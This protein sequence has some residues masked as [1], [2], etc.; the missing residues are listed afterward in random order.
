MQY[1]RSYL[2]NFTRRILTDIS[3]RYDHVQII[4]IIITKINELHFVN[5]FNYIEH[6]PFTLVTYCQ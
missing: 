4:N 1:E 3:T 2:V 6:W 5:D